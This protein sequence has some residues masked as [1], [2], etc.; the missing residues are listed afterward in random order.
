MIVSDCNHLV[1][2][3]V[4]E[5][6]QASDWELLDRDFTNFA[7]APAQQQSESL[8]LDP[9]PFESIDDDGGVTTCDRTPSTTAPNR[10]S[11]E[12]PP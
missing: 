4:I 7:T 11:S 2:A 8:C 9:Q 12:L 3:V 1:I 5:E 6:E 10:D